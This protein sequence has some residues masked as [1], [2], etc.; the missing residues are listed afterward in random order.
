MNLALKNGQ[1]STKIHIQWQDQVLSSLDEYTQAGCQLRL[2]HYC[3]FGHPIQHILGALGIVTSIFDD[4]NGVEEWS[5]F[6]QYLHLMA[7]SSAFISILV[8]LTWIPAQTCTLSSP[9]SSKT[10]FLWCSQVAFS[11]LFVLSLMNLAL[12]NGQHSTKIHIQWQDQVLSSLDEYT[13]AGC[14]L[15]L[16]HYCLFG[17]PIQHILG[18]LGIVTSIFDDVNGVEEWSAFHQYLHLMARSSAFISRLVNPS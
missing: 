11:G 1:H 16:V 6:H 15:R 14:Q 18:A 2:V 10:A 7:R 3:L 12:K 4:V 17:H 5:A 13:Q 9:W 8:Y